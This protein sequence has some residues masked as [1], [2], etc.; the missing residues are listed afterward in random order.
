MKYIL[1]KIPSNFPNMIS[2]RTRPK[3]KIVSDRSIKEIVHLLAD[4]LQKTA[5]PVEGKVSYTHGM[6]RIKFEQQHF[7]SPQ[8]SISFEET[9]SHKTIIRGMYGP[10]PNVWTIFM[11]SKFALGISLFFVAMLG[12]VNLY[13]KVDAAILWWV[14]I[15]A[16][17]IIIVWAMGQVG[18]KI[19]EQQTFTLHHFFEE[20]INEQVHISKIR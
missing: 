2:F 15:L 9:D 12:L 13:L 18:Q 19:G 14:P 3:F 1:E 16:S 4:A 8:L 7:W 5:S 10:H 17:G 11:L 20:A 6:L